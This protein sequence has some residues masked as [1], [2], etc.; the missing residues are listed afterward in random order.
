MY[1][2][3]ACIRKTHKI[4]ETSRV[5]GDKPGLDFLCEIFYGGEP[6]RAVPGYNG[7]PVI[8]YVCG[9][10][11]ERVGSVSDEEIVLS[12][13][14]RGCIVVLV[15]CRFA[16]GGQCDE[17]DLQ[18]LRLKLL[19]EKFLS[20]AGFPQGEYPENFI[21][22]SGCDISLNHVFWN[23]KEHS[24]AGTLEKIAEVWNNDFRGVKGERTVRWV[25]NG[26]RKQTVTAQDGTPPVWLD[27]NGVP[28]QRGEYVKI[29]YTR[30]ETAEDCVRADGSPIDMRLYMHIIYPVK[31]E[32]KVPVM[33]LA[34][35]T[36]HLAA[37]AAAADRPHF[38]GFLLRGYAG[39]M[40]DYG[41]VPM[42]RSD[43]YGYFDGNA[44]PG[45]VTG[46]N[47]TYSLEFYNAKKI[48][49]A[50]MRYVRRLSH[51]KAFNFDENAVGVF[52]NSKGGW[53][54]FLGEREPD[55]LAESRYY[56]SHHGETYS[57]RRGGGGE[58]PWRTWRG[59]EVR[60]GADFVYASCGGNAEY[61][62]KGH[63]PTFISCNTGD[64]IFASPNTMANF[65]RIYNVPSLWL[66]AKVGHTLASG[67]DLRHGVDTYRALFDFAGYY[68]KHDAVKVL[69]TDEREC[70]IKFSGPIAAE[71]MERVKVLGSGGAAAGRWLSSYGGTE[72]RYLFGGRARGEYT[73]VLPAGLRAE[74][75]TCL[76]A[77]Y[78]CRLLAPVLPPEEG[79]ALRAAVQPRVFGVRGGAAASGW[80]AA[81]YVTL[82]QATAP[83]GVPALR[84]RQHLIGSRYVNEAYYDNHMPV[85][86]HP[87][88]IG[89]IG[90]ADFGRKFRISLSVYDETVRRITAELTSC[91]SPFFRTAD[92]HRVMCNFT[93]RA[94]VWSKLVLDYTVYDALYGKA[95][96]H[97]KA[98][99]LQAETAGDLGKCFYLG[100]LRVEELPP[101]DIA[102]KEILF[103][104]L[105]IEYC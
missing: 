95:G 51:K 10:G 75:G 82:E 26:R 11:A 13:L 43:H 67:A 16:V 93:T 103:A 69:Y 104:N 102:E 33:C 56:P 25:K 40:Y 94:G 59:R 12:M 41:Y 48:N 60:S 38:L 20:R 91:T 64:G 74:N 14:R 66:E 78:R 85:L 73:A 72:W 98:L 47:V 23:I 8:F 34:S 3:N 24:A 105:P 45:H 96:E 37:G 6:Q 61:I 55:A 101:A 81:E 86:S 79:A 88:A 4:G 2:D 22:P 58:Q 57:E 68:L 19:R 77:E 97:V 46:D 44:A 42:A 76:K 9:A 90:A 70:S 53:M 27:K 31:P 15:N 7:T 21:V 1:T 35:S 32:K 71:Q 29:K 99:L 30:A 100:D 39:V 84:V 17:W 36:E 50:A 89:R 62:T 80:E 28:A 83:D 5:E 18:K 54:T 49:T 52:G 87:Q 63:A 65:C 92:Y